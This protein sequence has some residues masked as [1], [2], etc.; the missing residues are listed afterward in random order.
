MCIRDSE[1][2]SCLALPLVRMC[3]AS[4]RVG[5]VHGGGGLSSFSGLAPAG[6]ASRSSEET[7]VSSSAIHERS[8]GV[9][10]WEGLNTCGLGVYCGCGWRARSRGILAT[11][12]DSREVVTM[13]YNF[14]LA[15][16]LREL[17]S[18]YPKQKQ[19]GSFA[20]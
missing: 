9:R 1:K 14:W 20:R 8:G 10:G 18:E 11:L 5:T 19:N 7:K 15:H 16:N 12:D 6:E 17:I 13:C 3:D 2:V 4:S